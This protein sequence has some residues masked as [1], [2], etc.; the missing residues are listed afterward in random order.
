M[1]SSDLARLERPLRVRAE[2][3]EDGI[4][5]LVTGYFR[6][7]ATAADLVP[8]IGAEVWMHAQRQGHARDVQVR[9]H[10]PGAAPATWAVP[11]P[12]PLR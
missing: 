11:P 9:V 2:E 10:V 4:H 3:H 12:A 1:C 7:A 5:W 6:D 8:A